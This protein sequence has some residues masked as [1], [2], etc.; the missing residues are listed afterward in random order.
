M[1]YYKTDFF[2]I[3]GDLETRV[4]LGITCALGTDP[5]LWNIPLEQFFEVENLWG[6]EDFTKINCS[7]AQLNK[8]HGQIQNFLLL[9]KLTKPL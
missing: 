6:A 1:T 5:N 3:S 9:L 2:T 8:N 4:P 7:N